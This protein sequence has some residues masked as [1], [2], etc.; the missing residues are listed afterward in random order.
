MDHGYQ[1]AAVYHHLKTRFKIGEDIFD[2]RSRL[3]KVA[4]VTYFDGMLIKEKLNCVS[5]VPSAWRS[6]RPLNDGM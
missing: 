3:P 6:R 2:A 1:F 4:H 5:A